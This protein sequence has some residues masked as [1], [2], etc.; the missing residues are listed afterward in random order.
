L[1]NIPNN[2]E[3]DLEIVMDKDVAQTS[4]SLP[5]HLR[6]D[7]THIAGNSLDG[8]ADYFKI[9]DHGVD[10]FLVRAEFRIRL[11]PRNSFTLAIASSK[12]SRKTL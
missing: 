12:S 2:V 10:C 9:A 7:V 4:Y 8:L 5:G 1:D 11:S 6:M 3:I